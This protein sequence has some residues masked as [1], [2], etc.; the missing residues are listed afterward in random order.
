M[1]SSSPPAVVGVI[2]T[3]VQ[4]AWRG[5][6]IQELEINCSNAQKKKHPCLLTYRPGTLALELPGIKGPWLCRERER[7]R[8]CV[9]VIY[10]RGKPGASA[11]RVS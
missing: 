1:G 3:R 2:Q 4:A 7:E 9:C 5:A 8:V 6:P 10:S 11:A